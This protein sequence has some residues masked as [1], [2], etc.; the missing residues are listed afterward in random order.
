[1]LAAVIGSRAEPLVHPWVEGW[2][3][4]VGPRADDTEAGAAYRLRQDGSAPQMVHPQLVPQ[5]FGE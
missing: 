5:R 2:G 4:L 3:A 1:V